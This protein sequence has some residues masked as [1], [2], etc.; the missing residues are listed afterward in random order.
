MRALSLTVLL[1]V[2]PLQVT[3]IEGGRSQEQLFEYLAANL[4]LVRNAEPGFVVSMQIPALQPLVGAE[5]AKVLETFGFASYDREPNEWRYRFYQHG[6]KRPGNRLDLVLIF[7][8][9]KVVQ[10][11]WEIRP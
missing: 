9:D 2:W 3:A 1:S 8:G 4:R 6:P 11:V 7:S 10:A 5:K